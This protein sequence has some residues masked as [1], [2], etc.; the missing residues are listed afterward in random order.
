MYEK[1]LYYFWS[2]YRIDTVTMT[3]LIILLYIYYMLL[4][5]KQIHF[6]VRISENGGKLNHN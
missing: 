2:A 5:L 4:T 3:G 1:L 6:A